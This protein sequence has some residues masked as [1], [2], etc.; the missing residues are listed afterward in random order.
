M[1]ASMRTTDANAPNSTGQKETPA[2]SSG[3][4]DSASC[5]TDGSPGSSGLARRAARGGGDNEADGDHGQCRG[6][7]RAGA[8][9]RHDQIR[10]IEGETGKD[11]YGA[12]T[13]FL[14]AVA[15]AGRQQP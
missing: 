11:A 3:S 13:Q 5:A 12:G 7:E 2:G 8:E 1:A 4:S 15:H 10:L 6:A 9:R 14:D